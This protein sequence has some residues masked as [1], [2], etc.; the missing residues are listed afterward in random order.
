MGAGFSRA[1]VALAGVAVFAGAASAHADELLQ[2]G[3]FESPYLGPSNWTYPG[4]TS[5]PGGVPPED[6]IYPDPTLDGWTYD[7]SALVNGQTGSD[8]FGPIP[9]TGFGGDQFAALQ[10]ASTLSQVF[11]S[12]GS[13]LTL[14]WLSGGRPNLYGTEG[15]DQT[16]LVELDGVT[17]GI[18]STASGE[19]FNLNSLGLGEVSA[20]LHTLTFQGLATAD[21]T[22]FL[23]N[24]S[25][26]T[27]PEP[28]TWTTMLL[29]FG[30]LSA[31]ILL[32][33]KRVASNSPIDMAPT[34]FQSQS[35]AVS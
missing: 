28:S 35:S 16:Y 12:P 25:I 3:G 7:N 33:K 22:A 6:I 9:P 15:G 26:A 34:P 20:G 10:L 21:E 32:R 19:T 23:D 2:N 30:G 17:I 1:A 8:W 11:A 5:Y 29:G 31:A 24:V 18:F 27:V 13:E 4:L 14:S